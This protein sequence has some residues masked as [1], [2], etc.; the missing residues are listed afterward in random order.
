[1]ER[2]HQNIGHPIKALRLSWKI[3][4]MLPCAVP[5]IDTVRL[6]EQSTDRSQQEDGGW[7]V[8]GGGRWMNDG[9]A[10]ASIMELI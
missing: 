1:M 4:G 5:G 9:T 6:R 10:V 7:R 8:E 3:E 2:Q